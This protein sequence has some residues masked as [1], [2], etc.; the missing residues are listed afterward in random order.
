VLARLRGSDDH[1][2]ALLL[3][4]HYDS[5][6]FGP[7]ASDDGAAVA[8][9]I[10][11]MRLLKSGPPLKRD[12]ILL[13]SDGEELRMLGGGEF[14]AKHPW[15]RD[16]AVALNFDA[17]G[18]CGPSVMFETSEDNRWIIAQFAR[19]A[20]A[21]VASSASVDI[22]RMMPNGTDFTHYRRAGIAGLN[23]A[24]IDCFSNY[25]TAHDDLR[26]ASLRSMQHHGL[27]ALALARRLANVEIPSPVPKGNEIYFSVV[28]LGVI[29]Y[30][31]EWRWITAGIAVGLW[32]VVIRRSSKRWS[33]KAI[34]AVAV[35]VI[36]AAAI[37]SLLQL[38]VSSRRMNEH[39]DLSTY[40]LWMIALV[41]VLASYRVTRRW[42]S[43][44]QLALAAATV[45]LIITLATCI[46]LPMGSYLAAWPTVVLLL[47]LL[48]MDNKN[49]SL[50]C[51]ILIGGVVPGVVLLVPLINLA[52]QAMTFRLAFALVVLPVM[53]LWLLSMQIEFVFPSSKQ[54]LE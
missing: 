38:I 54:A 44:Q 6:R 42:C 37:A 40:Q 52:F 4:A 5:V 9:L 26:H 7:G 49:P 1:D 12:V 22:Y 20:P 17:R 24:Y 41:I 33:L 10:E 25:H 53:V 47:C 32:F 27:Y 2:H 35:S 48:E 11:V 31:A 28:R 23:F 8:A 51:A 43:W 39:V 30:A 14:I 46:W 29:H 19:A 13:I 16:V 3:S 34:A 36:S 21:P 15:A 50:Q 18:T 45:W